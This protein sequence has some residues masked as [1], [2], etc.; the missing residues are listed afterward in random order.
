MK[1]VTKAE[2]ADF[3]LNYPG[4]ITTSITGICEP[5]ARLY[6]DGDKLVAI[7]HLFENYPKGEGAYTWEPNTYKLAE[8]S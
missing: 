1:T 5:M 7:V 4:H 6:M 2:F 3:I 8:P